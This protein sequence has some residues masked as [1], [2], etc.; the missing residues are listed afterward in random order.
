MPTRL[1]SLST[2]VVV[3]LEASAAPPSFS[4]PQRLTAADG[5]PVRVDSPCFAAPCW[6]DIDGDEQLDCVSS[7]VGQFSG[8]ASSRL[9]RTSV[10]AVSQRRQWLMAEGCCRPRCP[11]CGD[12]TSS[13][14]QFV[15]LDGDGRKDILSGSYFVQP[16]MAGLF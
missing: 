16:E 7:L 1:K 15:D 5:V 10:R 6:A 13:T 9:Q 14:P 8:G 12:A 3:G 4:R 2:I 11:A